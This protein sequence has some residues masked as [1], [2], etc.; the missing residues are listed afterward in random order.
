MSFEEIIKYF[1][2]RK[3]NDE[4]TGRKIN[5]CICHLL[6]E[7]FLTVGMVPGVN[8]LN[9]NSITLEP[10]KRKKKI[11]INKVLLFS[12]AF[13]TLTCSLDTKFPI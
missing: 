9:C 10:K 11:N 7:K 4:E 5:I 12:I 13:V 3:L 1:D 8:I 6:D 2:R